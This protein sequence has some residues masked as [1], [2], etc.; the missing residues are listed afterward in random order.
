MKNEI[1]VKT[2]KDLPI[3]GIIKK[4]FLDLLN[5]QGVV[6]EHKRIDSE[7][8]SVYKFKIPL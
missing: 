3:T 2:N 1:S 4:N 8:T 7:I 6:I 5:E